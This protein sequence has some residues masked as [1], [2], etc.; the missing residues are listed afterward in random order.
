[1]AGL[2][3]L[4][5]TAISLALTIQ[6]GRQCLERRRPY[7]V[8]WTAALGLFTVGVGCQFLA[9]FGGWTPTLYRLWYLSGAILA[10]AYLGQ[11]TAYLMAPRRVAHGLMIVLGLGTVA[12]AVLALLA[13]VDLATA[14]SGASVSGAGMPQ[15]VRLLTPFFNIYGT[16]WL[17]GGALV[18]VV[19]FLTRGGSGQRA[20]GTALIGAGAIVI[21]AGG[22]LTR[23]GI[24]GALYLTELVAVL[25]IFTGFTLTARRPRAAVVPAPAPSSTGGA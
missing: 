7:Q 12:G 13:P 11:G 15:Y 24:P 14:L 10:A 4:L 18:S 5:A 8:V 21:A 20:L 23:F 17:V 2:I 6:V 9:G 22:T 16:L 19:R 25:I 3:S 1:M